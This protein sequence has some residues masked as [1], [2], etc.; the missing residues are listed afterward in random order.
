L[1]AGGSVTIGTNGGPKGTHT[2]RAHVDDN[3]RFAE[4]NE[5]NNQLSQP[6]TVP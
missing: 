2:I 3:N 6:I 1:A 4:S 5:T